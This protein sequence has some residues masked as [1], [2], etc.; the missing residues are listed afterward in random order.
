MSCGGCQRVRSHLPAAIRKLLEEVER[1]IEA[2]KAKHRVQIKYTTT[3]QPAASA[4]EAP[5]H[6]PAIP[7]GGGSCA[8]HSREV[9]HSTNDCPAKESN[10]ASVEPGDAVAGR[11]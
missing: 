7:L 1:R 4:A 9:A 6:L 5:R 3:S 2:K 10:P 8:A 11:A